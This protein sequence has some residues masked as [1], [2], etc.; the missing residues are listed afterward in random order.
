MVYHLRLAYCIS[1]LIIM[2]DFSLPSTDWIHY[3]SPPNALHDR[4]RTFIDENHGRRQKMTF[5]PSFPFFFIHL[6]TPILR[7]FPLPLEVGPH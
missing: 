1:Q 7:F 2:R 4:F 5:L 6:P 3:A